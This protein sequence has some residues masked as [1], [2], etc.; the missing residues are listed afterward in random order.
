MGKVRSD[1][2]KSNRPKTQ[3]FPNL[4]AKLNYIYIISAIAILIPSTKTSGRK[5]QQQRFFSSSK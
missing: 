3:S 4:T 1:R 5:N 2:L